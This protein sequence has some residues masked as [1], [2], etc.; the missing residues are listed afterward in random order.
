M[1]STKVGDGVAADADLA[2]LDSLSRWPAEKLTI[3]ELEREVQAGEIK[4]VIVATPDVQGKLYGKSMPAR[5]FLAE[6]TLDLSSGPLTYDN[7]WNIPADKFPNV[8]EPNGWADMHMTPDMRSLR[9]LANI[10][11]T[12]IV[13][14]HG[15]W[16]DGSPVEE[17]PRRVLARQLDRCAERGLA[18]VCAVEAEFYLFA[19]DYLSARRKNYWELDR[20]GGGAADYSILHLSLLDPVL[21][22]IRDQSMA[23]GIPIETIKHE[24]GRVQVELTLTYS[25]AMEAADRIALFKLITKEVALRHG[26]V[27]TFMA[28]YSHE[29]AGSS[30]HVHLSVW[31]PTTRRSLMCDAKD[32]TALGEI[33][34]HWLG[35]QMALA[36][37]LMLLFCPNVNSYKRLDIAAFGPATNAW[38][39]DGRSVPFRVV[40][41]GPALRLEH[42]IP[43]AD[44]NFYLA[45]AGM[46]A[47]GLYGLDHGLEPI[48]SPVTRGEAPGE[49]LPHH[50]ADAVMHFDSSAVV[51]EILGD[52]VVDHLVASAQH[53]LAVFD[54]EVT[55]V[56][57]RRCFECS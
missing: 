42:R 11:G 27:A 22:E 39:L 45:L 28:R 50:L 24:W 38:S 19:E 43:G 55:D 29:E 34:R 37:D 7:D 10:S 5:L 36:S 9:R 33:G 17:L 6:G 25:D 26:M 12:A 35:G 54:R 8:G 31:D 18:V 1:N 40:G 21:A 53:E 2:A 49:R 16:V 20:L 32:P 48:G 13:M 56:E 51:R 15:K 23:S 41:R 4:A 3:A 30:G 57:R 44:A 52:A 47:A 14:A 46:V